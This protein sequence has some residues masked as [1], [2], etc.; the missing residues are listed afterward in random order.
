MTNP[1][2]YP[3]FGINI[4]FLHM[5]TS[6]WG[7]SSYVYM[8]TRQTESNLVISFQLVYEKVWTTPLQSILILFVFGLFILIEVLIWSTFI[9]FGILNQLYPEYEATCKCNKCLWEGEK[10]SGGETDLACGQNDFCVGDLRRFKDLM[11]QWSKGSKQW[12][13]QTSVWK[14][15]QSRNPLNR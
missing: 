6:H 5:V 1:D 7:D 9:L 15:Q 13:I 14:D 8:E 11:P 12:V 10:H 4:F 2:C 3:R